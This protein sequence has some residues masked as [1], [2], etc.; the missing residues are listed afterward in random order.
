MVRGGVVTYVRIFAQGDTDIYDLE[1]FIQRVGV[2]ARALTDLLI[3]MSSSSSLA[4]AVL[5]RDGLGRGEYMR[6]KEAAFLTEK[7]CASTAI[8]EREDDREV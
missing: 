3:N 6:K 4:R 2:C 8:G 1:E 7:T 5:E